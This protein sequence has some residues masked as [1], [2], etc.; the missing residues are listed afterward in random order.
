MCKVEGCENE[1][2]ARGWCDKHYKRWWKYGDPLFTKHHG[3]SNHPLY[4][5]WRNMKNRCCNPND[6]GYKDYGGRGV[7][8]CE[9]WMSPTSFIEWALPLWKKGLQIDRIDNDGDYTPE[10]CHFVT[11]TE[12]IHN[13]R[14]LTSRNTSGYRGVHRHQGKWQSRIEINGQRK[15]LGCF[16]SAINAAIAFD[17]AIPDNRPRN[18]A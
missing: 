16:D 4:R 8:V 13:Q 6:K 17:K 7:T 10:N 5:V 18:F 14:L 15:Y 2:K 3:Y 12:N 11:R 1:V 9:E